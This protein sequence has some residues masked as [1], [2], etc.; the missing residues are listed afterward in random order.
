MKRFVTGAALALSLGAAA[1]AAGHE[2]AP[3]A[4]FATLEDGAS[5]TSPLKVVFGLSGMGVAPAGVEREMTGH[6]HV[7]I[8]RAPWGEGPDDAEMAE[9]GLAADDAHVHFGGGQTEAMLDLAPGTYTLQ[10]VL[11]DAFHVPHDPPVV[12]EQITITVTE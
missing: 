8:N 2:T 1:H 10:L 5:V 4:Y 3:I 7:L 6:H 9:T 12:S 11:G